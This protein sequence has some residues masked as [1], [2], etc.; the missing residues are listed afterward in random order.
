MMKHGGGECGCHRVPEVVC[1]DFFSDRDFLSPPS[2]Q[3]RVGVFFLH[4]LFLFL[5]EYVPFVGRIPKR[6]RKK[7]SGKEMFSLMG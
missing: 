2:S 7:K 4:L 3:P 1:V 6:N 5:L